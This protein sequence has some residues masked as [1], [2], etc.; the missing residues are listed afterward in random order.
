[1][2]TERL[3]QE[4]TVHLLNTEICAKEILIFVLFLCSSFHFLL[5]PLPQV[6]CAYTTYSMALKLKL[7]LA[8][9]APVR[10][11]LVEV[12]LICEFM[13]M[14]HCCPLQTE[15][16]IKDRVCSSE[17]QSYIVSTCNC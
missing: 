14:M 12:C 13:A 6:H 8:L 4:H 3:K 5:P 15:Q 10:G 17:G 7:S 9:C 2:E 11:H 1:M 16:I